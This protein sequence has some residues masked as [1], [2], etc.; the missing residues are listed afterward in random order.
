[1]FLV[2]CCDCASGLCAGGMDG[3]DT[4]ESLINHDTQTKHTVD[5]VADILTECI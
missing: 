1:M 3:P 2:L 4:R 5:V